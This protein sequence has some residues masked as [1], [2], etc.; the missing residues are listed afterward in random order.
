MMIMMVQKDTVP[1]SISFPFPFPLSI[2]PLRQDSRIHELGN[3]AE[4]E[5]LEL[6]LPNI[7]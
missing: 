5:A 7:Y 4:N 1:T 6:P 3:L 2:K